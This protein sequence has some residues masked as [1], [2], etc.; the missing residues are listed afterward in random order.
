MKN[1]GFTLIELLAVIVILA[2]I[3]LIAVPI[4][5]NIIND[6]KESS[7]EESIKLYAKAI[8]N[9]IVNYYMKHPEKSSVSYKDLL[10]ENLINYSGTKIECDYIHIY[11]NKKLYLSKCSKNEHKVDFEYAR[12]MKNMLIDESKKESPTS[13]TAPNYT[14]L[15]TGIKSD[16]IEFFNITTN[17]IEIPN[18][19]DSIDC[20]YNQDKSVMCYWKQIETDPGYYEMNIAANGEIY[21]PYDSY[22]LFYRLGYEKLET[23][24]LKGLNTKDSISMSS[25]FFDAGRIGMKTLILGDKFDTKNVISMRNMFHATG[26]ELL[27]ELNLGNNF[28]TSNVTDMYGMFSGTGYEK[29]ETLILGNNFDTSNVENMHSM[30]N[31]TGYKLLTS[32]DL[33]DKF[34]TS[35]VKNMRGM[36]QTTGKESMIT[37]NLGSKFTIPENANIEKIFNGCGSNGKLT[38]VLVPNQE[39][40]TKI[41]GLEIGNIPSFWND[42]IVKVQ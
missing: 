16:K 25:M 23:L 30:F 36:F 27:Q 29:M 26:R 42:T 31:G 20:S 38:S 13:E 3:A 6:A 21:T 37:L 40:K 24:N 18:G 41:L 39:L 8:E 12:P 9:A 34:D 33:G 10:E 19:Y 28:D 32:L 11:D 4:V 15:N 1:K 17:G 14:F 35:N 2:I 5:I 22:H 7:E